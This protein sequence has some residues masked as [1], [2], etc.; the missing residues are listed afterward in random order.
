MEWEMSK[1]SAF[2]RGQ[3]VGEAANHITTSRQPLDAYRDAVKR[4]GKDPEA[5][6]GLN[7]AIWV[8]IRDSMEP[9]LRGMT[10]QVNLGAWHRTLE[11]MLTTHGPL[12]KEVLGAEGLKRV[13]VARDAIESIATGAKAGSDTAINLQVHAALAST[14]LSRAWAVTTGRVPAGFG[15]A[16]RAMQGIIKLLEKRTALQ[17]EEILLEAF[18]N[19]K[20]FQTL[21]NA[22]QYGPS[23]KLVQHQMAQHLHVMNMSEQMS[24]PVE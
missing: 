6:A 8:G 3:S 13:E 9:K 10:G 12:M 22:A 15:F 11:N 16:E 14:W 4:V 23:N 1:A 5:V 17:Q 19:P 18:T 7:K 21:V 20:M 2:L 24:E